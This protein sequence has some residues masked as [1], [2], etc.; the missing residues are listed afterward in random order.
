M[1]ASKSS[2]RRELIVV[3]GASTGIG[4]AAARR[5]RRAGVSRAGRCAPP[6][7]SAD[8]LRGC[9]QISTHV[10]DITVEIR[11]SP[12]SP[13]A[14]GAI[15]QGLPAAGA[16]QRC[17]RRDQ[18]SGSRRCR[19]PS[20]AGQVEV[21]DL[22]GHVA[23]IQALMPSLLR[24]FGN[25]RRHQLDRREGGSSRRTRPTPV[26][27]SR[28]RHSAARSRREVSAFRGQGRRRRA[29]R[30]QDRDGRPGR[31]HRR[32]SLKD[33]VTADRRGP[34]TASASTAISNLA[35]VVRQGRRSRRTR[36]RRW[37]RR[38]ATASRPRTRYTIGRDAALPGAAVAGGIAIDSST[39]CVR[40]ILRPR[41][42]GGRRRRIAVRDTR[43]PTSCVASPC[44]PPG[45]VSVAPATS[46]VRPW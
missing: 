15:R 12:P 5:V 21:E 45:V 25:R 29:R 36:R 35:R 33:G 41:L 40:L 14:S 28:S 8:A 37:S 16:D 7:S 34:V 3:T 17:G 31:G 11:T 46:T 30:G 38:T 22:F 6:T 1:T 43:T 20:G 24:G 2:D 13:I 26:P 4:A 23:M 39:A 42:Q 9:T 10:L 19:S 44:R 32:I 18:R 27:S